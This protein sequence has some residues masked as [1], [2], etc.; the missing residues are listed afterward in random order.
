MRPEAEAASQRVDTGEADAPPGIE[1]LAVDTQRLCRAFTP[2]L[3][4]HVYYLVVLAL[5]YWLDLYVYGHFFLAIFDLSL[6]FDLF[7]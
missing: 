4:C 1:M 6:N 7:K 5:E 2:V 3:C